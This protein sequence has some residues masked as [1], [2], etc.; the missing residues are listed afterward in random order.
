MLFCHFISLTS[1]HCIYNFY[2]RKFIRLLP[3]DSG[4]QPIYIH[5]HTHTHTHTHIYIYIYIWMN[6]ALFLGVYAKLR[7]ATISFVMSL[8]LSACPSVCTEQLGSTGHIFIKFDSK[9]FLENLSRRSLY[10]LLS[11]FRCGSSPLKFV[12][13]FWTHL[14]YVYVRGYDLHVSC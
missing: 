7:K 3:E 14:V 9:L 1:I 12:L 11:L 4:R 5:T 2:V 10:G 13:P 8:R 6:I